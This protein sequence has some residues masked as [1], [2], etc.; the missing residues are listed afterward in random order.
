MSGEVKLLP[1]GSH[2][3]L[4]SLSSAASV[5]KPANSEM[6]NGLLV[7]AFGNNVRYTI[8]GTTP[9]ASLGFVIFAGNE[10]ILINVQKEDNIKFI[11]ET[12]SAT[13]QYQ[14]VA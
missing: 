2:G 7:Q 11:E 4:S 10:P 14:F 9:T 12:A 13:L 1:V 3:T 6:T 5:T 8:D